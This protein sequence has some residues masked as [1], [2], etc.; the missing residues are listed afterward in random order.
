MLLK[1]VDRVDRKILF[2]TDAAVVELNELRRR[3]TKLDDIADSFLLSVFMKTPE[4]FSL[5]LV[6][7]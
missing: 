1:C 7:H 5:A 2:E 3:K 4:F 6:Q